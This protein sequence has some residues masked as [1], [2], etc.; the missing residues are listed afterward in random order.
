M[1]SLRITRIADRGMEPALPYKSLAVFRHA[2]SVK[3]SDI[4][5]VDHPEAGRIVKKVAAVSINGR[6]GL[7]GMR[8]TA[9]STSNVPSVGREQILGKL[10]LC[11][12]WVRFLPQFGDDQTARQSA[13]DT[14]ALDGH[15]DDDAVMDSEAE[16]GP[17]E[18]AVTR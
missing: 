12:K 7:R 10:V 17:G 9:C 1:F 6:I 8:R 13:S 18:T 15:S 14:D 2:K 5:L 11:V 4:V 3:R 16:R